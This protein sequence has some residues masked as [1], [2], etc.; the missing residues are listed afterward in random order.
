MT[1][2]FSEIGDLG[3]ERRRRR[4]G[5]EHEPLKEGEARREKTED[6]KWAELAERLKRREEVEERLKK[7]AENF[8]RHEAERAQAAE[9]KWAEFVERV[10]KQDELEAEI[11]QW[12]EALDRKE[13]V[14]REAAERLSH[15]AQ[16]EPVTKQGE[17]SRAAK[18]EALERPPAI[19]LKAPRGTRPEERVFPER[20]T[21]EELDRAIRQHPHLEK[22]L[23]DER[24][25]EAVEY[26]QGRYP[27]SRDETR[28]YPKRPSLIDLLEQ[29][30][31]ARVKHE[32]DVSAE[33]QLHRVSPEVVREVLRRSETGERLSIDEQAN[34]VHELYRANP[35]P[36]KAPVHYAELYQ[37]GESLGK[38]RFREVALSIRENR[39]E[40]ER[41]LNQRLGLDGTE[42]QVRIAVADDRLY[43]WTMY[44]G[45][46]DWLNVLRKESFYFESRQAKLDLIDQTSRHL[47]VRGGP[48]AAQFYLS[49]IMNQLSHMDSPRAGRVRRYGDPPDLDGETL[50]F[51][52]DALGMTL[53][54][55]KARLSHLGMKEGGRIYNLKFP[56][57]HEYRMK[58]AAII[59]SD[60][61]HSLDDRVS[62][63]EKNPERQKI[64]VDVLREFGY[65]NVRYNAHDPK[66]V[67]L[68]KVMSSLAEG[69]GIPRGDKGIHNHG[70]HE[71]IIR[72]RPEVKVHYL[73]EVVAQEG[74]VKGTA[75]TI[76]RHNVLHAG[77]KSEKYRQLFGIEPLVT[78][79]HVRL[80]RK[81]GEEIDKGL[82]YE[83]GDV[84][85]LLMTRLAEFTK[86]ENER[87]RRVAVELRNIVI[88]NPNRL[89]GDERDHI[90]SSFGIATDI[91]I[92]SLYYYKGTG[93]LSVKSTLCTNGVMNAIRW[94]LIAPPNHPRK[95]EVAVKLL[96]ERPYDVMKVKSE[97]ARAGLTV[98]SVWEGLG[99]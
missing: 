52:S 27:D 21:V 8:Q 20:P 34:I 46:D 84:I 2:R 10:K 43:Y 80:V 64:G 18:C 38:D 83:E 93:R 40:M 49:D 53:E 51:V 24:Y 13:R 29:Q 39:A 68:P 81:K 3:G 61:C 9:K 12:G 70:L 32:L 66:R 44:N 91:R 71:S 95:M 56:D 63:Y 5:H 97:M 57:I 89:L 92:E 72:E 26:C 48:E 36:E 50:H 77:V 96:S 25:S 69:F 22:S 11:R 15:S 33:A 90:L 74:C 17:T 23:S 62:Y 60:G 88:S 54:D 59:D 42:K 79:E 75:V 19:E 37:V 35:N 65:F 30:E 87:I 67:S 6:E 47:H 41:L 73:P 99:I 98:S 86:S 78:R 28:A 1:D 85:E 82:T 45:P 58:F 16:A 4:E 7:V 31:R 55:L 76:V 94:M 14:Q